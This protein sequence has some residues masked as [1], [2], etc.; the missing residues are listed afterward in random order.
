MKNDI[1]LFLLSLLLL[2]ALPSRAEVS[3][4]VNSNGGSPFCDA[5]GMLL[6]TGCIVRVGF[7]DFAAPGNLLTLQTSNDFSVVDA[8]FTPLGEGIAGAGNINQAGSLT[9]YLIV[10]GMFAS[11]DIFGQI[12]GIDP[13]YLAAGTDLALWV[14][15]NATPEAASEWGIYTASTGWEFPSDLGSTVLSTFE[16]DNVIRGNNTGLQ[17]QLSPV[18]EPGGLLLLLVT[19][20]VLLRRR[21]CC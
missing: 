12:T 7:F 8:L 16:I 2:L 18:P 13:G 14:Y 20:G 10:N 19:G 9:N 4:T 1:R 5:G 6:N 17:F 3:I 21:R 15:N 11:G